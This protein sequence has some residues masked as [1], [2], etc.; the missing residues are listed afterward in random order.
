MSGDE[1]ADLADDAAKDMVDDLAAGETPEATKKE[2]EPE[3]V[4]KE[5]VVE[6]PV[7]LADP[8]AICQV[9]T[10]GED[11]YDLTSLRKP[12]DMYISDL[13]DWEQG[14]NGKVAAGQV[15]WNYCEEV[16][17]GIFAS[18][19]S[20]PYGY[21]AI[22]D[23][24]KIEDM[25]V[26]EKTGEF[27]FGLETSKVCDTDSSKNYKFITHL[28]CDENADEPV[29]PDSLKEAVY[30]SEPCEYHVK[31]KYLRLIQFRTSSQRSSEPYANLN[32]N[33]KILTVF[34]K[35]F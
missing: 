10:F 18:Y 35:T 33:C 24:S 20:G 30:Y 27:S 8:R 29:Y 11:K 16:S 1:I 31:F 32:I 12:G 15:R 17:E 14:S 5:P 21:A 13:W 9:H 23:T 25:K 22:A 3:P 19:W 2:E 7:K 34:C 6:E 26:D 4:K 28:T